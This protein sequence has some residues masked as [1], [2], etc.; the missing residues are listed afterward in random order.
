MVRVTA[1]RP[2]SVIAARATAVIAVVTSAGTTATTTDAIHALSDPQHRDPS[3]LPH[4]GPLPS[5]APVPGLQR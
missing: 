2:G 1:K 3:Y 4:P 5:G